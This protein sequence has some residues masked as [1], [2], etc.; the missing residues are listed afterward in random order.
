MII[1]GMALL[2]LDES[3]AVGNG[4]LSSALILNWH[5]QLRLLGN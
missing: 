5:Q 2:P 4:G 1:A 3:P